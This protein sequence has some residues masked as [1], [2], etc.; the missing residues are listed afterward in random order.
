MDRN[1]RD[2]IVASVQRCG[3]ISDVPIL[4][5]DGEVNTDDV[6]TISDDDFGGQLIAV[7]L[8]NYMVDLQRNWLFSS[9]LHA[10]GAQPIEAEI[11]A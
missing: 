5:A 9:G 6:I 10:L 1:V 2:T 11:K 7:S 3:I 4:N 8:S